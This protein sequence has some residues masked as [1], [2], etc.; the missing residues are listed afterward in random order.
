MMGMHGTMVS[1]GLMS[2][3]SDPLQIK[4]QFLQGRKHFCLKDLLSQVQDDIEIILL[5]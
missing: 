1:I 2:L 5:S 4:L 3:S